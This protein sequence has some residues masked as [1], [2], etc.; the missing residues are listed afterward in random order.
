[1]KDVLCVKCLLLVRQLLNSG[2]SPDLVNEDGLTALHQV[3]TQLRN[4]SIVISLWPFKH[5]EPWCGL[6][7]Y[8]AQSS[9][10]SYCCVRGCFWPKVPLLLDTLT[11]S[12]V[13]GTLK[14]TRLHPHSFPEQFKQT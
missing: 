7:G 14:A 13:L 5:G 4:S 1:M 9:R 2:I 6:G 10:L 12:R 3:H 8:V 11:L